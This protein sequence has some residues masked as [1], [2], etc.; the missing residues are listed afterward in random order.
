MSLM[1]SSK[2][3]PPLQLPIPSKSESEI[4]RGEAELA[5]RNISLT[6]NGG[7]GKAILFAEKP[8]CKEQ[9]S[10]TCSGRMVTLDIASFSL[11]S[12]AM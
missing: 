4:T 2:E 3:Y 5:D 9:P 1:A 6:C 10:W 8:T 11:V 12:Q 7:S